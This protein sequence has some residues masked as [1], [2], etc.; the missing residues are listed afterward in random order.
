MKKIV[1]LFFVLF[2]LAMVSCTNQYSAPYGSDDRSFKGVP[3]GGPIVEV[4]NEFP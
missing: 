1:V 3:P 4:Q 2:C